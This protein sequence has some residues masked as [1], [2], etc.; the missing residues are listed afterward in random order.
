MVGPPQTE[1][2]AV[3]TRA[4]SAGGKTR[5]FASLGMPADASLPTALLLDTLDGI[6]ADLP[7]VVVVE[8][9]DACTDVQAIVPNDVTVM[10]QIDGSLGARMR[11]VFDTLLRRGASRVVL[12]GSDLP[13][14]TPEPIRQTFGMLRSDPCALV[15]G[16]A[17]DGG[18]YLI[19]ASQVPDVFDGIEW[20]TARVFDQTVRAAARVHLQV[21]RV[22]PM[23]DVDT[24]DDV[25][26]LLVSAPANT[27]R[28]TIAWALANPTARP[29]AS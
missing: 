13:T 28:R 6:G 27:A 9:A 29:N 23:T 5:L 25:Q 11:T 16:P 20:G 21:H 10:P 2:V 3:L 8:P 26:R 17:D 4:P 18:Y 7:R 14:I 1:V 19:G 12:V 22:A 15:L 24:A